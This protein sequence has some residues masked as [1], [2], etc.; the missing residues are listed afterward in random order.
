[1]LNINQSERNTAM[2]IMY[3][4]CIGWDNLPDEQRAIVEDV[5]HSHNDGRCWFEILDGD[6]S[7]QRELGEI[8]SWDEVLAGDYSESNDTIVA[9]EELRLL[10][11][12]S[13][14]AVGLTRQPQSSPYYKGEDRYCN[15]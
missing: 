15:N 12:S 10:I 4:N 14:K 5:A 9:P 8:Y 13:L 7:L 3:K 6:E 2:L 11:E 1:M